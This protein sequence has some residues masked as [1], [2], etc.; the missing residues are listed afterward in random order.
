MEEVDFFSEILKHYRKDLPFVVY[1]PPGKSTK[2]KTLLQKNSHLYKTA[3]FKESGFVFAA[4]DDLKAT[5]LLPLEH[6]EYLELDSSL[7]LPKETGEKITE[8]HGAT[9]EVDPERRQ[10][11]QKLVEKSIIELRSGTLE[12]VVLSRKE[13]VPIPEEDPLSVFR[14]LLQNYPSA[15]VYC[16]YHPE[17]GLWLGATPE[18]LL[19]IQGLNFQTMAL[20]GTQAFSGNM[21][22]TWGT[23]EK[24]EQ[25][26]VTDS[27][28]EDLES[29]EVVEEITITEPKTVRA[30]GLLHIRTDIS[31][32]LRYSENLGKII[33]ALHPT[34]AVCGL[35][36]DEAKAF[37]LKEEGYD[38]EYYT[39]FLGEL[40]FQEFR[41][42]SRNRRNTENLAYTSVRKNTNLY[43]NL[44]CMKFSARQAELF[45]GGGITADSDPEKEWHETVNKAQTMKKVLMK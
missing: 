30:G 19:N 25:Q 10:R 20:A 34:P 9:E 18:T 42:R 36:K 17:I 26:F 7:F 27:I 38:R 11:H 16:W 15:F 32:K 3:D 22:A 44:R 41:A 12:K 43:V 35:P 4:F 40:N 8:D 28:T 31:G 1:K 39:G 13:A 5:I 21:E 29:L 45:V 23:K 24:Q 14:D 33:R 37:I 2:I 6:S